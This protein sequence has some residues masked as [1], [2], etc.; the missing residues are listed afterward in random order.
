MIPSPVTRKP[1]PFQLSFRK[2]TWRTRWTEEKL[3]IIVGGT[4]E[5]PDDS[6]LAT[7]GD[8]VATW[9]KVQQ[10]I[11]TY[12][13]GLAANHHVPLDPPT[14]GGFAADTCGFDSNPAFVSITVADPDSP[15]RVVVTFYTGYPD[16]Y[17]TYAVTLDHGTPTAVSAFAS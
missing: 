13:R 4:E 16:G 7:L 8:V 17:A 11:A 10:T 5:A 9:P 2:G 14:R 1:L 15:N 12:V 3:F 6:R